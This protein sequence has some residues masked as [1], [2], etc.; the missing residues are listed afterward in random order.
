MNDLEAIS[1][2]AKIGAALL[3]KEI[4]GEWRGRM[5]AAEI[6]GIKDI[7][8]ET[9]TVPEWSG[10]TFLVR[11]LT[12]AQRAEVMQAA[13]KKDGGVDVARMWAGLVIAGLCDPETRKPV[14]EHAHRDALMQKSGSALERIADVVTR[15]SKMN[16]QEVK[17]LGEASNTASDTP[18]LQ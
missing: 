12:G 3:A 9:V 17:A 4:C 7:A 5:T 13:M 16:P 2:K 6:I 11:A 18:T 8:E 10:A 14:F 15:L 1:L